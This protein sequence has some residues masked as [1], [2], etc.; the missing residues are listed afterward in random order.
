MPI[1]DAGPSGDCIL[2]GWQVYTQVP[3]GVAFCTGRCF[4]HDHYNC[5]SHWVPR[6]C[7]CCQCAYHSH[8]SQWVPRFFA[9]VVD[10]PTTDAAP[11]GGR[12]FDLYI[13]G[14]QWVPH[15]ALAGMS[16]MSITA[17]GPNGCCIF[18]G[19]VN[20]PTT[21]AAPNGGRVFDLYIHGSQWVPHSALAGMSKM[22]TT[23]TGAAFFAGVVNVPTTVAAPNGDRIFAGFVNIPTTDVAP[24]GGCVSDLY[25]RRSQWVPHSALAGMSKMSITAAGPNGCRILHWQGFLISPPQLRVPLGAAFLYMLSICPPKPWVPTGAASLAGVVNIFDMPI[26]DTGPNGCRNFIDIC[27][28]HCQQPR[29]PSGAPFLQV[30][31]LSI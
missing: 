15:S 11:N 19:V 21:D 8:W 4:Q 2:A 25:I 22:S 1:T 7:R 17:V 23:A 12:V 18:A 9:G 10:V 30:F 28:I 20:M 16:K 26:T 24:N 3:M 14:S 5:G 13:H 27:I 31:K 29:V 6:C